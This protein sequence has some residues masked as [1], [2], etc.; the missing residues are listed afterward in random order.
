MATA[1]APGRILVVGTGLI[2]TSVGLAAR[3]AGVHVLL[4][5]ADP[6]RAALAARAGAGEVVSSAPAGEP[7]VVVIAG[8]PSQTGRLA[9]AMLNATSTAVVTHVSSVQTLPQGEVEAAIPLPGRFVG[10][11]PIAGRELSG[12]AYASTDLFRDRPWVVTPTR[13]S[14]AGA[15]A[16]VMGLARLCG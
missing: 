6:E 9:I 8:P 14:D 1:G 12:P 7:D 16:A 4:Q 10:G 11:H 15:V 5:D 2:G 13:M 3:A